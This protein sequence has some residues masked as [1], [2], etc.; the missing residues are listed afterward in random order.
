MGTLKLKG[1]I[2][3]IRGE[4]GPFARSIRRLEDRLPSA[5]PLSGTSQ[6]LPPFLN[7]YGL[8]ACIEEDGMGLSRFIFAAVIHFTEDE[9]IW[10]LKKT[11]FIVRTVWLVA[12][13]LPLYIVVSSTTRSMTSKF[14]A[15]FNVRVLSGPALLTAAIF[16]GTMDV[17]QFKRETKAF[18]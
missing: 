6:I 13:I 10:A 18:K 4:I 8:R 14:I 2:S 11:Y 1:K 7:I 3:S 17:L 9:Q 12:G 15:T 16:S 5:I